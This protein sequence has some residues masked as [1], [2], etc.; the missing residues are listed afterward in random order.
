MFSLMCVILVTGGRVSPVQLLSRVSR[1]HPLQVL[2]RGGERG[3]G[4]RVP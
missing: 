4:G 3:G 1:V 2:P